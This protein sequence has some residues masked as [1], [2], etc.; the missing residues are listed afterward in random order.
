MYDRKKLEYMFE[1][2]GLGDK[3]KKDKLIKLQQ[4]EKAIQECK[5]QVFIRSG[6]STS[7]IKKGGNDA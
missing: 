6:I 2:I 7:V 5:D 1:Q 3:V 4:N